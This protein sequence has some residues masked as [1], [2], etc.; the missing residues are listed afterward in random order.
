MSGI[1]FCQACLSLA[2]IPW[3]TDSF[4]WCLVS[5]PGT[6]SNSPMTLCFVSRVGESLRIGMLSSPSTS[7]KTYEDPCP[8]QTRRDKRIER[9]GNRIWFSWSLTPGLGLAIENLSSSGSQNIP[10]TSGAIQKQV[11][12]IRYKNIMSTKFL[13]S[14][15]NLDLLGSSRQ[16]VCD[17]EFGDASLFSV[18]FSYF[19]FPFLLLFF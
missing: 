17:L 18:I 19:P 16:I 10:I 8:I 7:G 9:E 15:N 4:H 2:V 3:E 13:F 14:T 6:R 1:T 5:R 11:L 12:K